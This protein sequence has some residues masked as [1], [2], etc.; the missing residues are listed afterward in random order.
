MKVLYEMDSIYDDRVS[1]FNIVDEDEINALLLATYEDASSVSERIRRL[2]TAMIVRELDGIDV[3]LR[4]DTEGWQQQKGNIL[5][6]LRYYKQLPNEEISDKSAQILET[7]I[8]SVLNHIE[9]KYHIDTTT[10]MLTL[11][12]RDSILT[13]PYTDVAAGKAGNIVT[14]FYWRLMHEE[15]HGMINFL[16]FSP[17]QFY[18]TEI[19]YAKVMYFASDTTG[20]VPEEVATL[21]AGLVHALRAYSASTGSYTVEQSRRHSAKV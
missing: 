21:A 9:E 6:Y 10:N 4:T 3:A 19:E 17:N 16:R 20:A 1:L 14:S 2:K 5:E 7:I 11:C 8:D 12:E 13:I 18:L 15:I